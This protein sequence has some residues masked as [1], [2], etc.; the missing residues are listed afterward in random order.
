M[1]KQSR[2][3]ADKSRKF[4]KAMRNTPPAYIDLI[5]YVQMRTRCSR[6]MAVTV[7]FAGAL[8]VDGKPVGFRAQR[9]HK[10]LDQYIPA[11]LRSKIVVRMPEELK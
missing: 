11:E 8:T 3:K 10:V 5:V 4:E 7:L 2:L 9:D 1:G 6:R